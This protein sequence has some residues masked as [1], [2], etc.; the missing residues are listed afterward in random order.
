MRSQPWFAQ[1]PPD[2]PRTPTQVEVCDSLPET[3]IGKILR[4][5]LEENEELRR[6]AARA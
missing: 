5:K 2:V 3:L 4:R 1:N 6:V